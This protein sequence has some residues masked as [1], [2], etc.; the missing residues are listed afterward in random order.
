MGERSEMRIAMAGQT[1]DARIN[2]QGVFTLHLAEGL[3]RRGHPVMM[4][5]PSETARCT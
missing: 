4:F 2:G 1:Y 3:A 5:M